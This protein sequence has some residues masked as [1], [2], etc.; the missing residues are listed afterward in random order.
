MSKQKTRKAM[1]KR[2]K[3]T[4]NGKIMARKS[5]HCHSNA[6][7][8]SKTTRNKRKDISLSKSVHKNI[9]LEI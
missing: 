1:V 5:G 7:E 8:N 4:K 9:K 6:K 2:F 3:V